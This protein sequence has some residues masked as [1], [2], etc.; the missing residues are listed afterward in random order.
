MLAFGLQG[1]RAY[2]FGGPIGN[3]GDAYQTPAIGYGLNGDLNAPKNFGE[4][5]RRNIPVLYYSYN[6]NFLDFF[7]SNGVAAVD[8]AFALVNNVFTNNPSGLTNGL[9]GYSADLR[10]FPDNAQSLNFEA[11]AL[12]LT[13]LKSATMYLMMEQLGLADP[14]RYVWTLHDRFLDPIPGAKCP[15]DMLYLVVQRNFDPVTS[16]LNQTPYSPYINDVLYTYEI[17][18]FCTGPNPL[19]VTFPFPV[20]PFAQIDTALASFGLDTGGFMMD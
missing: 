5:Y 9:D 8:S 15:I 12:G 1:A 16:S 14:D 19:S 4:E 3:G 13:D 17:E 6:A 2:V 18:E 10:E 20:D 7:G 11:Q